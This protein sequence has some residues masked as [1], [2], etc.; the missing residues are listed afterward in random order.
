MINK[1][2]GV[3]YICS[4]IFYFISFILIS[5]LL[6]LFWYPDNTSEIGYFIIPAIIAAA[7]GFFLRKVFNECKGIKIKR[8]QQIGLVVFTWFSTT[9]FLT[10][11]FILSGQLDFSQSF[12]EVS[13]GL[14]TTGLSV[15]D[16]ANT[17]K[18][19]LMYRSLIQFFGG[20]GIILV[21][22]TIFLEP[23]GFE[24]Y[25]VEG[26]TERLKPNA[27]K[28]SRM[29]VKIYTG[30]IFLGFI[31]LWLSGLSGFDALN[32]AMCSIATGGF[33]PV[34]GSIGY[35]NSTQIDIIVMFLMI[36]GSL[37]F[38]TNLLLVGGKFKKVFKIGEIRLYFT[39]IGISVLITSIIGIMNTLIPAKSIIKTSF[40]EIISAIS[41]TGFSLVDYQ[42]ILDINQTL[43]FV[44]IIAM[45][46]GGA[47]GSTAGGI[48]VTRINIV[49]Q[50]LIYNM[51]RISTPSNKLIKKKICTP[52]GK[53]ILK[54]KDVIAASNY[55]HIYIFVAIVGTLIFMLYGYDLIS[56]MF[57]FLSALGNVGLSIGIT[58]ADMPKVLMW[59]LSIAM[60]IGR[61]EIFIVLSFIIKLIDKI[62]IKKRRS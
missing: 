32:I 53:K 36:L 57:E 14:S 58:T 33:A 35:Y 25:E 16:V 17:E 50:E 49:I 4:Y 60:F 20:I 5:P 2:K 13:S 7:I 61:L 47:L 6:F 56:S 54:D 41:G 19:F 1:Y 44:V 22:V 45:A 10:F 31:L 3:F 23:V 27:K 30:Y 62:K 59:T 38:Y 26:H 52:T 24:V 51:K 12:F 48:K 11:P 15:M 34:V 37:S 21:L 43:I 42:N 9:F 39:I 55:I 18:I 28:S 29:I 8:S 40:F 46:I